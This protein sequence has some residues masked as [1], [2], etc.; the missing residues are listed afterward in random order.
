MGRGS[1]CPSRDV[2]HLIGQSADEKLIVPE[3]WFTYELPSYFNPG[4][5]TM[6]KPS[7]TAAC[8]QN[9]LK[10]AL[11]AVEDATRDLKRAQ[12]T[13]PDEENIRRAISELGDAETQ[14]KRAATELNNIE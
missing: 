10:R 2:K 14:I 11:S 12:T 8:A 4:G 9:Y 6:T 1:R 3:Q 5:G 13:V 7:D